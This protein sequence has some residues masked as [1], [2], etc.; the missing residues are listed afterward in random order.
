MFNRPAI[1]FTTAPPRIVSIPG[2]SLI[3]LFLAYILP[4]NVGHAPWRGDDVLHIAT[5]ASMLR[6]GDWLVPRIAGLAFF[7]APPLH[8]WLGTLT[9]TLLGWLIPLHDAI[10]LASVAAL[11]FGL[12]ALREAGKRLAPGEEP[13][14]YSGNA[15]LLLAL[16]SMGLLIHAHEAQPLITLF[17]CVSGSL[18]GLSMLGNKPR[19]GIFLAS[20]FSGAAFL[21]G[22]LP[23]LVMTLPAIPVALTISRPENGPTARQVGAALLLFIALVA[24]WPSL[25]ALRNPALLMQWWQQ[26]LFD[27]R[28][29]FSVKRL[30]A[31]AN[32]ISWFAWPLWPLAGWT[33]WNR[34][35]Q[36]ANSA[37]A[38]PLTALIAATWIVCTTGSVRPAN[39]L[40]LLPPLILLAGPEVNRLRKGASNLLDWFGMMMFTLVGAFLWVSWSALHLGWPT[41]LAR[42]ILR[43]TPDFPAHFSWWAVPIAA[44]LSIGWVIALLGLPRFPL[45]GVLRWALGVTLAWGL[46]TT[47]W[48][49]WFDYDK[50]YTRIA[51]QITREVHKA[52]STCIMEIGAG[53][54]Q[55][56]ALDYFSSIRLQRFSKSNSKCDLVLSYRAGRNALL[57]PGDGWSLQWSQS[58]GRGRLQE[59]FALF[60]R[61]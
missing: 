36:L 33:L 35:H 20:G 39:A 50:N 27:L 13:D 19:R 17:A 42:N 58:K 12:W 48:L 16:S 37:Y 45:R 21:A 26:E 22:G 8:Y 11:A 40:P 55:R 47:L 60:R 7:D 51:A 46:A 1:E 34:R 59:Q 32:I 43:L 4:G 14:K 49:D 53:D 38:V 57:E 44:A 29:A 54:V 31:L 15:T 56:A 30:T 25:L 23:G 61:N 18:W 41:A 9:G 6:S 28:P 24:L 2:W 52:P 3:I 5:T 10:R